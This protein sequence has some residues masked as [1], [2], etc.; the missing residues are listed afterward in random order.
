MEL[1]QEYSLMGVYWSFSC[2]LFVISNQE[3][4]EKLSDIGGRL[5]YPRLTRERAQDIETL[6]KDA[7]IQVA[8]SSCSGIFEMK[9]ITMLLIL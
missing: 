8:I 6:W 4:G 3:I 7:A 1:P 2:I 9:L 5:D